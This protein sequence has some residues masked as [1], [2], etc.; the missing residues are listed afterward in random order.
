MRMFKPT[1]ITLATDRRVTENSSQDSVS[2]GYKVI[3]GC[4]PPGL[5]KSESPKSI[6]FSWACSS[7]VV[8]KKFCTHIVEEECENYQISMLRLSKHW[9]LGRKTTTHLPQASDRDGLLL[10]DGR[11]QQCSKSAGQPP[12]HHLLYTFLP[13][14]ERGRDKVRKCPSTASGILHHLTDNKSDERNGNRLKIPWAAGLAIW[15]AFF[16]LKP[17]TTRASSVKRYFKHVMAMV[18]RSKL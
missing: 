17:Q 15:I 14:L 16:G 13:C 6:A 8:N 4:H 5:M 1:P 10:A 12:S 11:M 7:L 9:S 18:C 2:I 3:N